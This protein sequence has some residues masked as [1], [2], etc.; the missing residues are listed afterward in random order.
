MSAY[1]TINFNNKNEAEQIVKTLLGI[2]HT[3][4]YKIEPT[5]KR[6][7]NIA[8]IIKQFITFPSAILLGDFACK[9]E[10]RIYKGNS[11]YNDETYKVITIKEYLDNFTDFE[12]LKYRKYKEKWSIK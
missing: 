6:N 12:P 7:T 10:W 5:I 4:T 8:E 11:F 1:L 9:K 2:G 3:F